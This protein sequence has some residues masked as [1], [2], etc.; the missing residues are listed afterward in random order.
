MAKNV[1]IVKNAKNAQ[2][3]SKN[4]QKWQK[5]PKNGQ[6]WS[7][8]ALFWPFLHEKC[9]HFFA[10][11]SLFRSIISKKNGHFFTFC[12]FLTR[13]KKKCVSPLPVRAKMQKKRTE[14]PCKNPL[15]FRTIYL[16]FR[17]KSAPEFQVPAVGVDFWKIL[18]YNFES[19][20]SS[21][22]YI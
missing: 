10:I 3:W 7:K 19:R 15:F 5:M 1:E 17:K 13:H 16:I 21:L 22:V 18:L 2:K 20:D 9:T 11:F 14:N 6:K 12:T 4:A 8:N